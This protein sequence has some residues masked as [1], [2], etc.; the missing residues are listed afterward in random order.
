MIALALALS[1]L[2]ADVD[3]STREILADPTYAFCH[4]PDY[5][6]TREEAT[7]CPVLETHGAPACPAFVESC[8]AARAELSGSGGRFTSRTR[9]EGKQSVEKSQRGDGG[10]AQRQAERPEEDA[11]MPDLGG[12]AALLFWMVIAAAVGVLA[13]L[14]AKNLAERTRKPEVVAEPEPIAGETVD[15]DERAA[16]HAMLTDVEALLRAAQDA[17]LRGHLGLA[18]DLG[19]AAL[20]RRLDH[21]GVI[22]LHRARTHGEYLVDLRE[23]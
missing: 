3:A 16:Q 4:E 5:P 11:K 7:W 15:A 19:H 2:D 10:G 13:W 1:L 22:R 18:I 8:K 9:E 6:L 21:E 23:H 14:V 17:E 20:L 12:L